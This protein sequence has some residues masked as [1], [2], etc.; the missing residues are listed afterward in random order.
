[1]VSITKWIIIGAGLIMLGLFTKEAAQTSLTG[2][3]RRTG[4]A[5]GSIGSALSGVG[6]GIGDVFR[7][8]FTPLWEV[9]NFAK[10]FGFGSDLW[11]N[12]TPD[13]QASIQRIELTGQGGGFT[14]AETQGGGNPGINTDPV[15]DTPNWFGWNQQSTPGS[16]FDVGGRNIQTSTISWPDRQVSLPLSEEARKWYGDIGVNVGTGVSDQTIGAVTVS[17]SGGGSI[18]GGGG[19][20]ANT[21]SLGGGGLTSGNFGGTPSGSWGF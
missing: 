12:S 15:G 10:S 13:P 17:N 16:I 21:S 14:D 3:L 5:G 11:G 18:G 1:M 6:G 7:G 19:A 20:G 9:G 8:L 4:M 2:T